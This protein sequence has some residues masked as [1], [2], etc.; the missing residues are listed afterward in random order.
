MSPNIKVTNNVADSQFE[1]RA[2]AG[3]ARLAYSERDGKLYIIHT[4]VPK[5]LEGQGYAGA[6]AKAAL[7]HAKANNLRVIPWCPFVQ[8]WLRRHPEYESLVDH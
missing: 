3:T 5:A 4:E 8:S 6:L 7:E 2:D 1:I